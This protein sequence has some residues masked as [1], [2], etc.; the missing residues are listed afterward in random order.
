MPGLESISD[1]V[2]VYIVNPPRYPDKF[3]IKSRRYELYNF[4]YYLQES[5]N[6]FF[7]SNL[8]RLT[9]IL[10]GAAAIRFLSK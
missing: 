9:H 2:M 3:Y 5:H 4:G 6:V 10:S 1:F 7:I 8:Q